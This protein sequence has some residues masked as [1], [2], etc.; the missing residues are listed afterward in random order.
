MA[1]ALF[2]LDN[3][4]LNGDSDHAWGEWAIAAG[5]LDGPTYRAQNDRFYADYKAG[6]LDIDAYLRFAL[7]PLKGVPEVKLQRWHRQFMQERIEPMITR[8]SLRLLQNH[9]MKGD[10]LL[11]ITAT[12]DFVTAPIA[13]RLGVE[14]LLAST[15]ERDHTG[16]TG[17]ATGVPCYQQGK[18]IR[19]QQWLENRPESLEDACF[20]SDSHND[21]PLLEVVANPVAVDPDDQLR[22]IA[23]R[24]N[25]PVIT[26]RD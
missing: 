16:Y 17:A 26:L 5:I 21:L 6:S 4:L 20:Y 3:T 9:R 2:D 11:I 13:R 23:T 10:T 12:N 14:H 1:L 8:R 19:L 22:D 25:W 15:A 7:A 18:V 24:R